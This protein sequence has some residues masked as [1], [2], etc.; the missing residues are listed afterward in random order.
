M[1]AKQPSLVREARAQI[2]LHSLAPMGLAISASFCAGALALFAILAGAPSVHTHHTT[3]EANLLA[4]AQIDSVVQTIER[5][6]EVASPDSVPLSALRLPWVGVATSPVGD[7]IALW[8]EQ[9]VYVSR[10]GGLRAEPIGLD[11]SIEA[12]TCDEEGRVWILSK[13]DQGKTLRGYDENSEFAKSK[14]PS[15]VSGTVEALSASGKGIALVAWGPRGTD[16]FYDAPGMEVFDPETLTWQPHSLPQWGNAGNRI[17]FASDGSIDMMGGSEASCGGGY[18]Y[19]YRGTMD[20]E[21]W[22]EVPWPMDTPY[23]FVIGAKGWSYAFNDCLE[24]KDDTTRYTVCGA[25]PDG[26]LRPVHGAPVVDGIGDSFVMASKGAVN[27]AAIGGMLVSL[28]GDRYIKHATLPAE[29][30]ALEIDGQGRPWL[31][32]ESQIWTWTQREGF[33]IVAP[34]KAAP[35]KL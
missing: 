24:R 28:N 23:G 7:T 16:D 29:V 12:V 10:D 25:D 20:D 8:T 33:Q 34:R 19:H 9:E 6:M 17:A 15:T 27:F 18:Q 26:K 3:I 31:L 13:S 22:R 11:E 2:R 30:L 32:T 5:P 14:V 4:P 1:S 21:E 35:A